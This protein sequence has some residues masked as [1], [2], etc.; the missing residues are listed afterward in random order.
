MT[1][2]QPATDTDIVDVDE[3]LGRC[4][5]NLQFAERIL[6]VFQERFTTDLDELEAAIEAAEM[7]HVAAITHRLKG[8]CANAAAHSLRDRISQLRQAACA[9]AVDEVSLHYRDLRNDWTE[10]VETVPQLQWSVDA[11]QSG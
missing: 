9:G 4:L 6:E 7:E 1:L 11:E 3:L 2:T 10:F 8:A 5:G